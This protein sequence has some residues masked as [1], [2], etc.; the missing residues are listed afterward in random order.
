MGLRLI[1]HNQ[2]RILNKYKFEKMLLQEFLLTIDRL[3]KQQ[4]NELPILSYQQLLNQQLVGFYL[5]TNLFHLYEQL[6]LEKHIHRNLN[7][8]NIFQR[9]TIDLIENY[10]LNKEKILAYGFIR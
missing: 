10:L 1:L 4:P 2:Q 6:N 3:L 7:I 9:Q 8:I 5:S